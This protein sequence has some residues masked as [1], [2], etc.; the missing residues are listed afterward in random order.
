MVQKVD[1]TV[2]LGQTYDHEN[3]DGN[4]AKRIKNWKNTFDVC[5][6]VLMS[7]LQLHML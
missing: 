1:G 7:N 5:Q 2:W 3:I 4:G 6:D